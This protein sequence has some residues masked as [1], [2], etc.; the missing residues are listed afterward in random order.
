MA[1]IESQQ[2]GNGEL[3]SP[4]VVEAEPP[5]TALVPAGPDPKRGRVGRWWKRVVEGGTQG[6]AGLSFSGLEGLRKL[7]D[8]QR[9]FAEEVEKQLAESEGRTLQLLEERLKTL[10]AERS[11]WLAREL[12]KGLAVQ[13]SRVTA[14]GGLAAV[15][16]VI[17][18]VAS[19]LTLGL[20]PH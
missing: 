7:D 18:V 10:E 4:E 13:R 19:L 9:K 6:G 3:H 11:E 15:A 17:A 14:V 20:I 16:L 1:V 5:Q 12:E 8:Q 2:V